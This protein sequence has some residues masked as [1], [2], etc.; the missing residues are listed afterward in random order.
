MRDAGNLLEKPFELSADCA[1]AFLKKSVIFSQ[2]LQRVHRS[3]PF[4]F[5]TALM[6]SLSVCSMLKIILV[7][8][9]LVRNNVRIVG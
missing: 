6:Q 5:L 9:L 3:E 4:S 2:I 8:L 1:A 7:V